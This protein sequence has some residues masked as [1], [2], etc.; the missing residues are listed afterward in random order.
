MAAACRPGGVVALADVDV[1]A[2]FSRPRSRA[3]ERSIELYSEAARLR[4]ADPRLGL[5]LPDLLEAAGLRW[6][7]A[8][9]V[10]PSFREGEG[11]LLSAI[12]FDATRAA[13]LKSGLAGEAELDEIGA[14]LWRAAEDPRTLISAPR[15]HQVFAI[16][17][18]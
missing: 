16:K 15:I 4:G 13:V 3:L 9:A 8:T 5:R 10:H 11:K 1:T 17:P 2:M 18:A 12:T 14:E 6:V 7:R